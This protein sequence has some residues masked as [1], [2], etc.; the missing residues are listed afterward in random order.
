[1]PVQFQF[2]ARSDVG[3]QR[4]NNQDSGYAGAHLL[5]LADG[6]GGPAGG[7]IAS[8][9]VV[10]EL[11]QLD[12]D[13]VPVEQ[14]M[15]RLRDALQEAHNELI[16]RSENDPQLKGLG[17]TCIAVLRSGN[18]LAMAHIGDSRA[19]LLRGGEL[20]QVTTDHSFV[21]YLV[22]SGQI[23]AEEAET[24]PKRSVILRVLGD[25]P[26]S[27]DADE[28]MREAIEGDRWLLCSDGLSGV[29]SADTIAK[30]LT[31]TADLD[32]C[33][34]T[35]IEL[36]LLGGAPDNVTVVL[37]DVVPSSADT[38]TAPQ[39]VG[40]A[41]IDRESPSRTVPGAAG[42]AAALM[43]GVVTRDPDAYEYDGDVAPSRRGRWIGG[44]IGLMLMVILGS[45]LWLGWQ[46]TQTQYFAL[47]SGENVVVY[48]GIP[49][50]LGPL[51]LG[52]PVEVTGIKLVD[53]PAIDRKRLEEPVS[54]TSREEIDQYLDDLRERQITPTVEKAKPQM[55]TPQSGAGSTKGGS[56]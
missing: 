31:E 32:E 13:T 45:G 51:E 28:T 30:V 26:G 48:R 20:T 12:E 35:L 18:K 56:S 1:M 5:V 27:I 38:P 47:A 19:Y 52:K 53:L 22:D 33:A 8:S 41:A 44:F 43:N 42:K 23:S 10:A 21:Q 11:S 39:V 49:Q 25:T 34:D 24:H 3:L 55:D 50:K 17:T 29:V 7:D 6:M 46:W 40:A 14:M 15:G 16:L 37:A 54:R 2:T 9:V 36:A 4:Q